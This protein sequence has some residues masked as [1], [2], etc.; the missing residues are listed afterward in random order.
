[1][2]KGLRKPQVY[3]WICREFSRILDAQEISADQ[4]KNRSI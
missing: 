1:M 4:A 2:H 3:P